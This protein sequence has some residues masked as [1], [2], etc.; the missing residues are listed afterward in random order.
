MKK[1]L[2]YNELAEFTNLLYSGKDYK[3]EIDF[4]VKLIKKRNLQTKYILEVAC[5]AANHSKYLQTYGYKT[6][7]VDLN[8]GMI[9]IA[10]KNLPN[11]EF[12]VQDMKKLE[13]PMKF[14]V[15]LCL[16]NSI[17]YAYGYNQLK[18]ILKRFANHL[19]DGGVIILDT[20][21]IKENWKHERFDAKAFS[22]PKLD[23]ARVN[24][25]KLDGNYVIVD[26]TYVIHENGKKKIMNN[27][28]KMFLFE[29]NKLK[30]SIKESGF[31][32]KLYYDL[33]ENKRKGWNN[34]IIGRKIK[35]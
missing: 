16:F 21:F 31:E 10:R 7:G 25:I 13:L 18:Q 14:D 8:E 30:E 6:V 12:Y 3:K 24:K 1:E 15:I 32:V 17:N 11:T 35:G 33:S 22:F 2:M 19:N 5:G 34:I 20:F 4:L 9:K 26:Q 27:I 28:N 29:I 23:V